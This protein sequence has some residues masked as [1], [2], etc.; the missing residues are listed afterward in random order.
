M[1]LE[2]LEALFGVGEHQIPDILGTVKSLLDKS[3]LLRI[4]SRGN[5]ESYFTMLETLREIWAK[6]Y[7]S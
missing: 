6:L 7:A 5:E 1:A 4:D 3:L 2:T